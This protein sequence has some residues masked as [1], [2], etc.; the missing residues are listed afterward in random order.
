MSDTTFPSPDPAHRRA[1]IA[2]H[3]IG[4]TLAVIAGGILIAK[5]MVTHPAGLVLAVVVYVICGIVSNLASWAYHFGPWHSQRVLLRRVDHA[6]IYTSITGT[7]TPFLVMISTPWSLALLMLMWGLTAVAMW[8]KI[9][10]P[11]VKSRW[12]TASYLALGA[13]GLTTLPALFA[14]HG[15]VIWCVA[16]GALAYVAGTVFYARKTLP[17]RYA[18]WH[19]F[20]NLGAIAMFVGIWLALFGQP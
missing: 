13:I 9:T 2:V 5:T 7:F 15:G 19:S 4:L 6:A 11:V 14:M 18:I 12:S 1:D 8:N 20:V 17:Y 16:A 3:A 10:N